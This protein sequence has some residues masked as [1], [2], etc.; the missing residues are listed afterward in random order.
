LGETKLALGP[1]SG[2]LFD[3]VG[4]ASIE[5]FMDS[6][7]HI[8]DE[9]RRVAETL[10]R[11]PGR[12][13]FEKL[14]GIRTSEWHGKF[15]RTWGEA[16]QAAG[17]S[18]N[19]LQDRLSS[20]E[21]LRHYAEAVRHFARIPA[22]IDIRMY[23]RDRAEFPGH[24]TFNKHFGSKVA[25]LEALREWATKAPGYEDVL[26][27]LRRESAKSE[28]SVPIKSPREGSVYLLRSGDHYK[29]GRSDQLEQRIKQITI[30]LPE[31]VTLE[32]TIRTDD[33]PGIEAYWHRRFADKRANGEWFR[34]T[35]ADVVA[36]KKRRFQ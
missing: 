34:L 10:D 31:K 23:S 4:Q 35:K 5:T 18:E 30:S 26:P 36:F 29:I 33:P 19:A 1:V 14:S 13:T 12:A 21:V 22:A 27:H 16:L 25:L 3:V 32:H 9:I 7:Q 20:E 15:W 2:D 11:P 8:I 28:A 24:T 6:R 17:F